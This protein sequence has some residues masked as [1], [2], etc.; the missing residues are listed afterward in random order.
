VLQGAAAG[1]IWKVTGDKYGMRVQQVAECCRVLQCV[2]VYCSVLQEG[3]SATH[4]IS[5]ASTD[6]LF[7]RSPPRG[8]LKMHACGSMLQSVAV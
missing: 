2:A 6:P 5:F 7:P 4:T 8:H 3:V 1:S